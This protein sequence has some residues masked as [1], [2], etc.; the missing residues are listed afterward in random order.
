M[1]ILHKIC[2]LKKEHINKKKLLISINEL[3]KKA[4]KAKQ[5]RGFKKALSS[6]VSRGNPAIIAEIKKGSPSKGIIANIFNPK[7]IA[8]N[9]KEGGV[10]CLSVLSDTPFFYGSDQDILDVRNTVDL[11]ILRKDFILTE[12]Q[13]YETRALGC[14][15]ILLILAI[16]DDNTLK[17]LYTLSLELGMDVLLEIHDQSELY[18]AL[19]FDKVM[20]GINN[21]N[22]NDF[23]VDINNTIVLYNDIPKSFDVISESGV[24]SKED[25]I[26][27]INSGI[28]RFLIGEYFMRKKNPIKAIKEITTIRLRG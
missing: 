3:E 17:S 11:P 19:N 9:Y 1:S 12:Y 28:D 14:D 16:L 24:S 7:K 2:K 6:S 5:T 13:V 25:V 15:C 8:L 23:S 22:L 27:T 10:T 26:Y 18:R 21:R 20:I 4:L